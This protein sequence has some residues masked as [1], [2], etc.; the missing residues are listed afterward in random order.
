[1]SQGRLSEARKVNGRPLDA[2]G[3]GRDWVFIAFVAF[4]IGMGGYTC[5]QRSRLRGALRRAGVCLAQAD[6]G[7]AGKAVDDSRWRRS[8]PARAAGT[9]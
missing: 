2:G 1:M 9:P 6:A 4:A 7:C 8:P 3:R 5:I